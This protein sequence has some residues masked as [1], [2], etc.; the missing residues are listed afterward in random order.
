MKRLRFRLT[1]QKI[2]Q[3]IR[4]RSMYEKVDEKIENKLNRSKVRSTELKFKQLIKS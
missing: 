2:N 4:V 3:L 1:D